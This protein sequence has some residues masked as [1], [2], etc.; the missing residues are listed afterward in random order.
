MCHT[1]QQE[2]RYSSREIK[3]YT[4]NID[5]CRHSLLFSHF[6]SYVNN[7]DYIKCKC[8]DVCIIVLYL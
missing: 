1:D 3:D 8:C 7:N 4:S 6:V 5:K 2:K